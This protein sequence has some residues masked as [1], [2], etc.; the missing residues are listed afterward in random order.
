MM[1][2]IIK[3]AK[4]WRSLV[5]FM[6]ILKLPSSGCNVKKSLKLWLKCLFWKGKHIKKLKA[7]V[8]SWWRFG[9]NE[10]FHKYFLTKLKINRLLSIKMVRIINQMGLKFYWYKKDWLFML[11]SNWWMTFVYIWI[12][13]WNCEYVYK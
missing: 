3:S 8:M 7:S 6:N 4:V 11:V 9:F 1:L 10:V 12:I 13:W 5:A 2:I